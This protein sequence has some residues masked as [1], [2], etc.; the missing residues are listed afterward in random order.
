[1]S[2]KKS[3]PDSL[4][5]SNVVVTGGVETELDLETLAVD[6]PNA[7][8]NPSKFPGIVYRKTNPKATILIFR[9][10]K[11]VSTGSKSVDGAVGSVE[12][13]LDK[14]EGIGVKPPD[15]PTITV[16]NIVSH[17]DFGQELNLN[18]IAIGLGLE[19]V[20]Y[21]PEQFPGL[22]YQENNT[23]TV[24]LMFASGKVVITGATDV[25][26]SRDSMKE[27]Y[28]DLSEYNLID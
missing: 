11:L 19:K 23:E 8:Y 28:D 10:G 24:G 4:T 16:S 14:M 15:E 3:I 5:V 13:I 25:A 17:G 1:M 20:E 2:I 6:L 7:D 27:I 26:Q 22:V 12:F 9:S 21:E 18:A